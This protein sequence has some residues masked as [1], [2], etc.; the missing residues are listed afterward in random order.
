MKPLLLLLL[1][2]AV[3]AAI[4]ASPDVRILASAALAWAET[5]TA[6]AALCFA[7]GSVTAVLLALPSTPVMMIAGYL[8]GVPAGIV[9][10][11]SA[12][13]A[14]AALAFVLARGLLHDRVQRYFSGSERFP[15]LDQAVS[16]NGFLAVLLTR[17]AYVVPFNVLNYACGLTSLSLRDFFFGSLL[18]IIPEVVLSVLIGAATTDI[19]TELSEGSGE[20]ALDR[21]AAV[22]VLTVLLVG[23]LAL[24]GRYWRARVNRLGRRP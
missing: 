14:G 12:Y 20:L 2:L 22:G 17:L 8:F 18:G 5:H 9:L 13:L 21:V 15:A 7:L 10:S 19:V 16:R 11:M 4:I 6:A 24:A 23:G 3:G 1:L